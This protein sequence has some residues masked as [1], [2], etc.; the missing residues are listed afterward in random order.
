[1]LAEKGLESEAPEEWV[2]EAEIDD[3]LSLLP[4]QLR[5]HEDVLR[6][7][8]AQQLVQLLQ[9]M[10]AAGGVPMT[11]RMGGAQ[12]TPLDRSRNTDAAMDGAVLQGRAQG[13]ERAPGGPR[14]EA[15]IRASNVN[16]RT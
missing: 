14:N 5:M 13:E 10:Q 8:G 2:A 16:G 9:Q 3:L 6:D 15:Q 12:A 4:I 7:L 11:E 1:M